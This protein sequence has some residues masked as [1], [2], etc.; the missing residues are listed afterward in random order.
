MRIVH[1]DGRQRLHRSSDRHVDKVGALQRGDSAGWFAIASSTSTTTSAGASVR[2][3]GGE[4]CVVGRLDDDG[5]RI[6]QQLTQRQARRAFGEPGHHDAAGAGLGGGVR[7]AQ[8]GDPDLVRAA[9]GDAELDGR[10]DVVGVHVH[11]EQAVAARHDHRVA[12][13]VE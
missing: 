13:L 7:V 10:L 1:R 3:V 9:S 8:P 2:D 6:R 12:D 11:V 5:T 4:R